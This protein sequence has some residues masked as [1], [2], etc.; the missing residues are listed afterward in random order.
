MKKYIP[1]LTIVLSTLGCCTKKNSESE[2]ANKYEEVYCSELKEIEIDIQLDKSHTNI[3][4]LSYILIGYNSEIET[5]EIKSK[6]ELISF[7]QNKWDKNPDFFSN[8][9][10][11]EYVLNECSKRISS[12]INFESENLILV[13]GNFGGP[14]FNSLQCNLNKNILEFTV[15]D[16]Q[17]PDRVSGMALRNFYKLYSVPKNIKLK[18]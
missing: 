5:N 4:Y 6:Q 17:N 2:T 3:D 8:S 1:L 13:N 14:P 9:T 12:K 15:I 10:G 11:K 18:N 7:L 16:R